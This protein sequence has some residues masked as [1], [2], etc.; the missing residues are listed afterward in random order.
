MPVKF[1]LT[2]SSEADIEIFK[3]MALDLPG[4]SAF[5]V[6]K[7]YTA[8]DYEDLLKEV[9]LELKSQRKNSKRSIPTW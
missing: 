1:S 2:P 9:G 8:Y 3:E 7:G 5:H 4:D 6:D